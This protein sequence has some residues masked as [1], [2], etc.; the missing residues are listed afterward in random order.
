[1]EFVFAFFKL[2]VFVI[3]LFMFTADVEL[4]NPLIDGILRIEDPIEKVHS[5]Y[6]HHCIKRI[7]ARRISCMPP[8]NS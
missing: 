2:V 7:I 1:M 5:F 4:N 8:I 6:Y 3:I